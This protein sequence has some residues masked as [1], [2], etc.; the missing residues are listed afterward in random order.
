MATFK[1]KH[2]M[3]LSKDSKAIANPQTVQMA[4]RT[5]STMKSAQIEVSTEIRLHPLAM[6][7]YECTYLLLTMSTGLAPHFTGRS[8]TSRCHTEIAGH[9]RSTG[10]C[11][12]LYIICTGFLCGV[13]S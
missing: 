13:S 7:I 1:K 9:F 6:I 3:D 12:Q 10:A 2:G 4:K 8:T 11:R 5:L